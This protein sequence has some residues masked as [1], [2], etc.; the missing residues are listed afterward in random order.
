[1]EDGKLKGLQSDLDLDGVLGIANVAYN[2]LLYTIYNN[3]I[4]NTRE[5]L[6]NCDDAVTERPCWS[7]IPSP[8]T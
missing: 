8:F 4:E 3:I 5:K 1:M 7:F 2:K 6:V